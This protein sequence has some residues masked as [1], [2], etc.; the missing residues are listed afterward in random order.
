MLKHDNSQRGVTLIELTAT[1]AISAILLGVGVPSFSDW[2]RNT[3]IRTTAEAFQNGIQ[4]ARIEAVRRNQT[5]RFQITDNLAADCILSETGTNWVVGLNDVAAKC[6]RTPA[7]PPALPAQPDTA[8]PYI[9]QAR[10]ASEG[11]ANTVVTADQSCL[12]FNGLGLPHG[13]EPCNVGDIVAINIVGTSGTCTEDGGS[14]R[15][16]RVVLSP[17]G[18]VRT[19]DPALSISSNPRGC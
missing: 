9:I 2:I 4:L 14:V 8:N 17:N 3:H 5:V 12:A 1:L 13:P 7:D 6:N 10:P 19:C 15:C 11:S 16:L 18:Q